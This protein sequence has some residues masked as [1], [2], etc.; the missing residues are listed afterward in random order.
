MA[1]TLT[2][3][4]GIPPIDE[5]ST[6]VRRNTF[7]I[8]DMVLE[9]SL[10]VLR[11]CVATIICTTYEGQLYLAVQDLLYEEELLRNPFSLKMW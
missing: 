11:I 9:N 7:C 5:I 8:D 1:P 4:D 2:T 3:T 10:N 6:E